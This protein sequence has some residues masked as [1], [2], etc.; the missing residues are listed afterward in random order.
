MI[1]TALIAFREFFEAFLIVG[2]FWGISRNLH[3][4]KEF[5]IAIAALSG[6]GASLVLPLVVYVLGDHARG[7]LTETNADLLESYLLIFSGV[8]LVYV[9]FSLHATISRGR[10]EILKRA[11]ERFQ[12]RVFDV[13][14]FFTILF[15]VAREGFEI[16]LFTASISLAS[17]FAQNFAGLVLGLFAAS[18]TGI[19]TFFAFIRFPI[20]KIFKAVEWMI[21]I[22]GASL[23][24]NGITMLFATHFNINLGN[25]LPLGFGFLPHEES[26]MGHLL[27]GLLGIDQ[28]FSLARLGIMVVYVLLIYIL[29]MKGNASLSK[30]AKT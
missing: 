19:S 9:I 20:H 30:H 28:A 25:V 23:F 7:F 15:L 21:I 22:L 6:I 5:E 11:E 13:S 14:L 24:Q 3:L 12:A 29:F 10:K 27:Q 8:F 2:V 17:P 1:A 18:L 26:L 4:K 16:A